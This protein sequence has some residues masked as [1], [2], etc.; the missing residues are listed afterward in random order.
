MN[1]QT[2]N[3]D[4]ANMLLIKGQYE[5]K[6]NETGFPFGVYTQVTMGAHHS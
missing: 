6:D 2:Y 3:T 4:D 1:V 5:D